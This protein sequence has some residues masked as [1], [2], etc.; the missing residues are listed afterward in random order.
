[1]SPSGY[2]VG[3]TGSLMKRDHTEVGAL[4]GG[5]RFTPLSI[6]LQDGICFF[7]VP[8]PVLPAAS[9]AIRLPTQFC[10]WKYGFTLFLP[11]DRS[12]LDLAY[13]PMALCQRIPNRPRNIRPRTF[14]FRPDSSLGLSTITAFKRQFTCVGLTTQP[15]ASSALLLAE[16]CQSLRGTG[17][18][19]IRLGY[20]VG[21]AWHLPVTREAP[22]PRLPSAE[23]RVSWGDNQKIIPLE[24]IIRKACASQVSSA[25]AM[26]MLPLPLQGLLLAKLTDLARRAT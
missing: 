14:W 26:R 1:M 20:V 7:R 17:I 13:P 11:S 23:R 22:T 10:G 12:G 5:V 15:C 8:L 3:S 6:P 2:D 9:L 16:L 19:T 4:S 18:C 25:G 21:V 24:T